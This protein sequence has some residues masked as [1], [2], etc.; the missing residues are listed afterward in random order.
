[1]GDEEPGD[2]SGGGC[3]EVP[4][5]AAAPAKPR[6]VRSTTQ[7]RGNNWKPL[8]PSGRSTISMV[9]CPQWDRASRSC[10]PR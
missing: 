2:L 10:L 6:K 5:E 1:M 9:H 8:T 7:R 3:L 4:G